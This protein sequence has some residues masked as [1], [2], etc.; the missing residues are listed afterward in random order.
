MR[1]VRLLRLV[2]APLIVAMVAGSF[3]ASAS[4]VRADDTI[5]IASWNIRNVSDKSR[6]DAELGIISLV[7]FRYD[8]IALQ[9]VLDEK[10]IERIQEILKQDF[11]VEYDFA[12]SARVGHNKKERYAFLWR[13]DK[14]APLSEARIYADSEDR[15]EREPYCGAFK[16]GAFDWTICTIHLLYGDSEA[17]RRP[18]LRALD[19]V[20]RGERDFGKEKDI[21]ICGDF[22]FAPDDAG[23]AEL[24]AEDDISF[25]IGPP[26]KTTIADKSLYDNCWWPEATREVVAGSGAVFEFD[27]LIYPPGTRKEANRLTSD[28]RPISI[29]VRTDMPDDD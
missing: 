16:A 18:E 19:D 12:V 13:K 28:H 21:L 29:R 4:S 25:A 9:E 3:L 6:S 20:Y 14:V 24:K 1:C 22:N 23:W 10:V 26:M 5:S 2:L 8:F 7:L 11:R 17:D 27:E 15:F